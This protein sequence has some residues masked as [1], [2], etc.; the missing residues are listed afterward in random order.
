MLNRAEIIGYVG[1]DPVINETS[2]GTT[3][4]NFSVAT[5]NKWTDKNGEQQERTEWHQVSIFGKLADIVKQY[6]RKG[7]LVYVDGRLETSEWE[8]EGVT[9]RK[10][11]IIGAN[12]RMLGGGRNAE[13]SDERSSSGG[14]G[15]SASDDLPPASSSD[16]IPF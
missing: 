7:T 5:T 4:A 3:V 12:M 1:K 11:S 6:V 14:S 2:S 8:Q 13:R 16:D 15:R 10:T 9:K